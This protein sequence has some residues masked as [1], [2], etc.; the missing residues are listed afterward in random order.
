MANPYEENTLET[1]GFEVPNLD[2]SIRDA[3]SSTEQE[4]PPIDPTVEE[5]QAAPI[6]DIASLPSETQID[7]TDLS[8][9]ANRKTMWK[10][11]R[12]VRRL[13][14]GD[15]AKDQWAQKYHNKSW[16]QYQAEQRAL[17]EQRSDPWAY[18]KNKSIIYDQEAMMAGA[19]GG[20]DWITDLGN[21]GL[22]SLGAKRDLLPKVPKFE[23]QGAQAFREIASLVV[24]FYVFKGKGMA[25]GGAIHKSGVAP[26]WLQ[27]LGNTPSFARFAKVGLDLGV[28]AFT[29]FVNKTNEFNDTLAT[30]W[31][32]G[33]WWGHELIPEKWTSDGLG[34][35]DKTRANVLEGVRLGWYTSV[36]EGVVKLIRAGRS[37]SKVTKYLAESSSNQKNLDELVIDPLDS[38]TYVDDAGNP[39][40]PVEEALRR[41]DDKYQRDLDELS[42]YYK[43]QPRPNEPTVGVHKF[44]DESQTGIITKDQDDI[45]GIARQQAQIATNKGTSQG[46]LGT[47]ITE[48]F[49]KFGTEPDEVARRSIV[50]HLRDKLKKAG[51]Y[52]VELPN[53]QKLSWKEIDTEGRILAAIVADPTL[54][55]KDLGRIIDNFK[56][57]VDGFKKINAVAYKALSK[58]SIKMLDDW[59]DINMH[60][61]QAYLI[62]SEASQISGISEGMRYAEDSKAIGRAN[63]LFLERLELFEIE[64]SIADFNWKQRGS[65]LDAIRGNPKD[66]DKK[67]KK[68]TEGFDQKLTD[69]IPKA[70]RFTKTLADI[71]ENNPEFAK[72]LRL[73]YEL[74]EGDIQSIKGLNRYIENQFGVFSKAVY[75]GR[76]EVPSLVHK[77][78]MTNIF[79]SML[80]A[81]G[82]PVKA[83]YGNFGGFIAEPAHVLYGALRT[84]DLQQM[85][86]ASYMYFGL[87]DTFQQGLTY[88]GRIFRKAA[89]T[90]DELGTLFRADIKLERAKGLELAEEFARASAE[91]GEYGPQVIVS[92]HKE[93]QALGSD[94]V[95]RFGP[96]AMTGLDGFTEAT[97][98]VAQDKGMAFDILMKKYPDG[99]WG[100]K[101]FREVYED[102]WKKGWNDNGQ[103]S[104]SAV[105]YSRREIALNLD[106]PL[107]KRLNPLIKRFP[108]L[109]SVF[110]FPNTQMNAFNIFGKYGHGSRVKIGTDFAGEY[111][112]LLGPYGV[113]RIEEF[114]PKDIQEILAKRGMD[115]SGDP[116]AKFKH[117]RNKVRGRVATG[118]LAVMGAWMLFSQD[119]IRGNGHWDRQV[120]KV[121]DSQGYQR[122]TYQGLDGKWHSYEW[123]GP[124]GEWLAFTV[125]VLDNFDSISTTTLEQMG[126]KMAFILGASITNKSLLGD[127][128]PLFNIIKGDGNAWA[129]W[130][131]AVTNAMFPLSG[132][133][134][135]L[136]KNMYGM[137]REVEDGDMGDMIRNRNQ[138]LDLIDKRGALPNVVD[139]VTGK[140]INKNGGSF[141]ARLKNNLLGVKTYEAPT[142][143]GQF[144]IDI[145]Y[146]SMPHF[147]VSEG[148]IPYS[149]TEKEEL[150]TLIGQDGY[151]REQIRTAMRVAESLTHTTDSGE[152]IKGYENIVR[153][154]RR[155][156]YSSQDLPEFSV[157]NDIL[158]SGLS[159]AK[160]R[161]VNRIST[162]NKI[163]QKEM[164]KS[165]KKAYGRS[166]DVQGIDRILELN[167]S[168]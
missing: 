55:R 35:N 163:R 67:I 99:K 138:W 6:G 165:M 25:M 98:K 33:R 149:S 146:D 158:D 96:N 30:S 157:I 17:Q 70:K 168:K 152:V 4:Q 150:G 164:E 36:A 142:P 47:A 153:Y 105:E 127:I 137:L 78:F 61:A 39:V 112:E 72:T 76:P 1:T 108:I 8:K 32:R 154:L 162:A 52:K 83:L 129:R 93:L 136:G 117:L 85:R 75:D 130:G 145:E 73:A 128:E 38:K 26:A 160:T 90:P 77:A 122:K 124:V 109:R 59:S 101:E 24:P 43:K 51:P 62:G 34:P 45:L 48:A 21:L 126:K 92:I 141:F 155:N 87:T 135:E 123:M 65:L 103:I 119:R 111:A 147:N 10:T 113:K 81:I 69:I 58:A 63:E 159:D 20:V 97:Q 68:L 31:K 42:E 166:E 89:T 120:Q 121:R 64:T 118:N 44:I 71:Q 100:N 80:S 18:L 107:T 54:P 131:G 14:E 82:T 23:N 49:R 60:K 50:K 144:L 86:R 110:W 161:V 13:P 91:K 102:L 133:R 22:K 151:F 11:L 5:G 12:E 94:P 56:V 84:G 95:L 28:G 143:E 29:D 74:S 140:P 9:R 16:D 41:S 167:N 7:D 148:G 134:N 66:V 79:N 104:Q 19:V 125:D 139:Y 57:E 15:P 156:G 132:L 115:M 2:I 27:R 114:D 40:S 53:G 88:A 3:S 46:S 37:T 116:I 106:T